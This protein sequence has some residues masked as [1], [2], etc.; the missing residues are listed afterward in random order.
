VHVISFVK[1][2][3]QCPSQLPSA[4]SELAMIVAT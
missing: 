2:A 1:G 3:R 4:S